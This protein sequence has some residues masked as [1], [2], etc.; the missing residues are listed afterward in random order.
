ME[1]SRKKN[2]ETQED[3]NRKSEVNSIKYRLGKVEKSQEEFREIQKTL[4]Q[5]IDKLLQKEDRIDTLI[6]MLGVLP[7]LYTPG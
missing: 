7:P 4:L 3:I 1:G 5:K 2:E 6:N